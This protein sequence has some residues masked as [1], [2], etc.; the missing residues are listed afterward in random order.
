MPSGTN[1]FSSS[2]NGLLHIHMLRSL[3]PDRPDVHDLCWDAL[4]NSTWPDWKPGYGA[5]LRCV[6]TLLLNQT[7]SALARV[8]VPHPPLTR[9]SSERVRFEVQI[10]PRAQAWVRDAYLTEFDFWP[11]DFLTHGVKSEAPFQKTM[12]HQLASFANGSVPIQCYQ[13]SWRP[14]TSAGTLL[15]SSLGK[16][17]HVSILPILLRLM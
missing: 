10:I 9:V 3:W 16:A 13:P 15:I 6:K 4:R 8:R 5:F 17:A 11:G 1:A 12:L 7:P 14:K 2:D